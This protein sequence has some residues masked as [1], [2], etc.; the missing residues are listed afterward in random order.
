MKPMNRGFGPVLTRNSTPGTAG[1]QKIQNPV[2]ES[3]FVSAGAASRRFRR[4]KIRLNH[5]PEGIRNLER[6]HNRSYG[7]CMID[8]SGYPLGLIAISILL[9]AAITF[10]ALTTF[11][12]TFASLALVFG[13]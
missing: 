11:R 12:P 7:S 8:V 3:A 9:T 10:R 1:L 5:D 13:G 4:G 6:R 2:E